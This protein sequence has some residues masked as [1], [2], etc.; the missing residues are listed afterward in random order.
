MGADFRT[1]FDLK[2]KHGLRWLTAGHNTWGVGIPRED[3][4]KTG[5]LTKDIEPVLILTHV[6]SYKPGKKEANFYLVNL[7][8]K[9]P[10]VV[11][12]D[13]KIPR[14]RADPNNPKIASDF[15]LTKNTWLSIVQKENSKRDQ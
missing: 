12:N 4:S 1:L 13:P 15:E 10:K 5:Q 3:C 9:R 14:S 2:L 11:H 8:G 7:D 6:I